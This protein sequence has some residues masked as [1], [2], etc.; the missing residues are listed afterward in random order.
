MDAR[1]IK[2]YR[3]TDQE[4]LPYGRVVGNPFMEDF[5]IITQNILPPEQGCVYIPSIE[6]MEKVARS[7]YEEVFGQMPVQIGLCYGRNTLLNALEWHK[8]SEINCALTDF[9]LMLGKME[10]MKNGFYD[11]ANIKCFLINRGES[12]ELYQTTLHFCPAQTDKKVFYNVVILP[13][14][15]NEPLERPT[16]DKRLTHKNKWLICHPES[17]KMIALDRQVGLKGENITLERN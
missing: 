14:G 13:K 6:E 16:K 17:T 11:T 8:S 5:C 15:T 7:Y 9:V 3:V 2:I 1:K 4:F 10:E 12:V